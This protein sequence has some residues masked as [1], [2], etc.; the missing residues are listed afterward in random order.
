CGY[1]RMLGAIFY[2]AVKLFCRGLDLFTGLVGQ[3]KNTLCRSLTL[4]T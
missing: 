2:L 1:L 4:R 3:R